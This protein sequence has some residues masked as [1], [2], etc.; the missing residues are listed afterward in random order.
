[1]MA[2]LARL[3]Q[4][5][6]RLLACSFL[7]PE[8]DLIQESADAARSLR[9]GES[10]AAEFAFYGSWREF[11]EVLSNTDPSQ[12]TDLRDEHMALFGADSARS[13]IP[14][15]ET[16][17]LEPGSLESGQIVASVRQHYA[18]AG[19][20]PRTTTAEPF[21]HLSVELEFIS[22]LCGKEVDAWDSGELKDAR[23]AMGRQRRFIEKH[24]SKW[25]PMVAAGIIHRDGLY[26]RAAAA[27]EALLTHDIDFLAA[28]RTHLKHAQ[29]ARGGAP[30]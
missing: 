27:A 6:Y 12:V 11:A 19:L 2:E 21:D 7:F 22:Y 13:S 3:R 20:A 4:A 8:P 15:T 26:A 9:D 1:M 23:I 28:A 5:A 25:A 24:P 10:W 18:S 14:L 30:D 17:Y 29:L 16:G